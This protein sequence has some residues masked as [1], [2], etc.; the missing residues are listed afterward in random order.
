VL[1]DT[2]SRMDEVIFE[3]FKSTGNM[4]LHLD[5]RLA[6]RRVWPALDIERSGTWR[7]ELLVSEE[8]RRRISLLQKV[9][10]DRKPIEAMDQ[11]K[12]R[13]RRTALNVDFLTSLLG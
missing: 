11:L 3:E 9:L 8:V 13:L 4:E 1:I 5:R 7:E 12:S 10:S 6:D 2:G